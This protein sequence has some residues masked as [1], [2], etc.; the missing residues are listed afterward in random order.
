[1]NESMAM[2]TSESQPEKISFARDETQYTGELF[3]VLA[4]FETVGEVTAAAQR[5]RDAGYQHWDVY[6]PFPIHGIDRSMGMLP[7]MLP[8]IILTG[9]LTGLLGGLF[10]VWWCNATSFDFMPSFLQGYEY[11]ISGKPIF[12][13]PANIPILFETTILISSFGAVFGMLGLNKLPMLYNPLFNSKN[14]LRATDDRFFIAIEATDPQFDR[15]NVHQLLD[16]VGGLHV[17]EVFD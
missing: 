7:T 12:S 1:M 6:S 15:Q 17:E 14:F 3:A 11:L 4:E 13:L 8:W 5:V 10:M 16:E 2:S 9:G